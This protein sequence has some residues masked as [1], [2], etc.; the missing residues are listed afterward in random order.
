MH[1]DELSILFS[2]FIPIILS[3]NSNNNIILMNQVDIL[4]ENKHE[5]MLKIFLMRQYVHYTNK[6]YYLQNKIQNVLY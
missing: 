5:E 1:G 3:E 2:P 6:L 4:L